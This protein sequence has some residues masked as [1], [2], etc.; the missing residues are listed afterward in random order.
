MASKQK[1]VKPE[2]AARRKALRLH[3]TIARDLGVRIVS[4]RFRPGDILDG[5]V[6][7]S[8]RLEVSRTAYRE[9]VRILSAKAMACYTSSGSTARRI[10]R[11]RAPVP[12]L[13]MTASMKVA[14]RLGLQW[15]VHAVHTR[16]VSSFEE[17]VGKAKRMVLRHQMAEAGDRVLIMAGVPFKTSGS[18]NVIHVVR[19]VG[20]ELENYSNNG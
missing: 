8:D 11:E 10:A 20:D 2:A 1:S 14:R 6:D 7:A 18:T 5:E 19:I 9:A 3:G 12:T 4:G 13:A 15:G 16:D 17:M